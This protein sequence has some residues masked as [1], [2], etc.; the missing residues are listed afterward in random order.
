MVQAVND[1]NFQSDVIEKSGV[2]VVDFWAEWCGPCQSML[3][4]LDDFAQEMEGKISVT[5]L[6]VDESQETAQAHRVMSIPTI[7]VFKDG[8][9]VEQM[10]GVQDKA[11]LVEV[12]SKYL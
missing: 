2:V 3:P 11:K 8:K 10:V 5:K 1:S 7:I 12:A 6:N 9:P 4:I